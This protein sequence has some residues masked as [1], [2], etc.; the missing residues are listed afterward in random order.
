M[1]QSPDANSAT[2]GDRVN[3]FDSETGEFDLD[4]EPKDETEPTHDVDEPADPEP[5]VTPIAEMLGRDGVHNYCA[6]VNR[7]QYVAGTLLRSMGNPS[8][9]CPECFY[10]FEE[11]NE[12][13]EPQHYLPSSEAHYTYDVEN[14]EL[15]REI[16]RHDHRRHRHCPEC[17]VVS[18]GG[19]IGDRA[20]EEFA[21]VLETVIDAAEKIAGNQGR[22]AVNA[23]LKRK[24]DNNLSDM[25]NME[26]FLRDIRYGTDD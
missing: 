18:F 21:E 13:S 25:A 17:G 14:D 16:Q 23:A 15:V 7:D 1:S 4:R 6:G 10:E 11:R 9:H 5:D 12:L 26:Q 20:I 3:F 24:R 19:I 2:L 8:I 22:R